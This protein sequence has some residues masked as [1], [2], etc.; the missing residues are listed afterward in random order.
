MKLKINNQNKLMLVNYMYKI[1]LFIKIY[2][3]DKLG[4]TFIKFNQF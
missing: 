2:E 4:V 3:S 1:I